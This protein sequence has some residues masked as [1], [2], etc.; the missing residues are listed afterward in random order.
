MA[1]LLAVI[2]FGPSVSCYCYVITGAL[3]PTC[4]H[5]FSG[6]LIYFIGADD[7][8]CKGGPLSA[9]ADTADS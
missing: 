6:A 1:C 7:K 3:R 9:A 4:A 2:V 8:Y 5:F